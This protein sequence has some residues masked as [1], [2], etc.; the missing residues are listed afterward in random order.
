MENFSRSM[1]T[2][3]SN[4]RDEQI[5]HQEEICI[6]QNDSI[7]ET[8]HACTQKDKQVIR[9]QDLQKHFDKWNIPKISISDVYKEGK[10]SSLNRVNPLNKSKYIIKTKE[11]ILTI[12]L[13]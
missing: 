8:S 6:N 12:L 1:S 3:S 7:I 5:V 2:S 13:K 10:L 9:P 4:T 11:K